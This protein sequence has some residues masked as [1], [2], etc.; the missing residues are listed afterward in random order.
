M[1]QARTPWESIWILEY[2]IY[3][4]I[5][6]YGW[7]CIFNSIH[8][9][10]NDFEVSNVARQGLQ[11]GWLP[12]TTR[13]MDL[14]DL[15]YRMFRQ[16]IPLL[17]KV[18]LLSISAKLILSKFGTDCLVGLLSTATLLIFIM[19]GLECKG[20]FALENSILRDFYFFV[21]FNSS[22][23]QH[24]PYLLDSRSKLLDFRSMC[25]KGRFSIWHCCIL[26]VFM[27]SDIMGCLAPWI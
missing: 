17:C 26:G 20:A 24:S 7:S 16:N 27:L 11:S 23:A 15:Q 8:E 18:A 14:K 1:D 19:P 21:H 3:G 13:K 10:S 6:L 2:F 25:V 4:C 5:S 12:W 22:R 9:E